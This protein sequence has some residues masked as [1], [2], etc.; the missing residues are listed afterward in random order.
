MPDPHTRVRPTT[1]TARP[2]TAWRAVGV[3]KIH[4]GV[5]TT[6]DMDESR[7]A[8]QTDDAFARAARVALRRAEAGDGTVTWS[9]VSDAVPAEQWGRLV[10]SDLLVATD[11]G[12]VVD[13]P[14]GVRAALDG[15]D[16]ADDAAVAEPGAG[17]EPESEP[18]P[19]ADDVDSTG[20]W[21]S[22]DRA[23]GV[24]ALGLVASYQIPGAQG[25]VG[26]AVH[27]LLGPV[28]A[29]LPFGL[30][31]A[32]LAVATTLVSTTVRSRLVDAS[33]REDLK[34][35]LETVSDRLERA[36]DR[37]DD[38]AVERLQTR[39]QEL[40]HRQLGAMKA[41]LRPM[42]WTMLVTVPVFL[43]LSW[44][45]VDPAGA[46]TPAVQ[47][48]PLAGRVVWT[49]RVVGPMQVWMVWYFVCSLVSNVLG[50]RLARRARPVVSQY[51][52]VV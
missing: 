45:T 9:D 3:E 39:R 18:A 23:A 20:E 17:P 11:A 12:F 42:A 26:S 27:L 52:S 31:I 5:L 4:N 22:A 25:T 8:L 6:P 2:V 44:L 33:A 49:A 24:A 50:K 51:R 15:R 21:S 43:W 40:L 48:L 10:E 38:D 32:L 34:D 13:D 30:T 16:D 37:G 1:V 7:D 28:E 35:R 46:I 19:P 29:T 14:D 47:V 36:R 41:M